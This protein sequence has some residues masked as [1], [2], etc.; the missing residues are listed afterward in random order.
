MRDAGYAIR[1]VEDPAWNAKDYWLT[2][3]F[4]TQ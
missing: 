1:D 3:M 4:N 2:K